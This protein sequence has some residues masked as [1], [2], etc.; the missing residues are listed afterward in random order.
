MRGNL[1]YLTKFIR[2]LLR[3]MY[4]FDIIKNINM[5]MFL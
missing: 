2:K 4:T 1:I 3:Y 5:F